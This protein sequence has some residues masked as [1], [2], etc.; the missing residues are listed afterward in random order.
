MKVWM[1]SFDIGKKNFAFCVEEVEMEK[2]K[3]IENIP[4]HVRFERDGE[5]TEQ[6]RSILDK[7]SGSGRLVLVRNEDLTDGCRSE[8]ML[9]TRVLVRMNQV[10]TEYMDYWDK[11]AVILI[12][13]QMSFGK[14]RNTMALKLGQHC[15]SFFLFQYSTFKHIVEFP[16]YHKT[17]VMG[18]SS[19]MS[20]YERKKWSV[21]ECERLLNRRG[22]E[23]GLEVIRVF[24][25]R[26]DVSDV[27]L[28]LQAYKYLRYIDCVI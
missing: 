14:K 4:K 11:C 12:E 3:A 5:P 22:D 23:Q 6:Y 21:E 17:K 19:K 10:L 24:K 1:A 25:K 27:V 13:Q 15:M 9:D 16:A 26:D 20:K 28:Q 2:L 18:G 8:K 7:V